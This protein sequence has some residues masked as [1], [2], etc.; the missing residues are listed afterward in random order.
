LDS[1]SRRAIDAALTAA[2]E[3]GT[4][5]VIAT[6]RT[7][8]VPAPITHE[9]RIEKGRTARS[10]PYRSAAPASTAGRAPAPAAAQRP[11]LVR[12]RRVDVYPDGDG[13]RA[14][15]NIDWEIRA[16]EHWAISGPNGAGKSTLAKLLF[17]RLR[18]AYGGS[19]ERF[20]VR[21]RASV[22]EIRRDVA[23]LSDDE[24]LRYDWSIPVDAVIASGFFDSVG[25]LQRPSAEQREQ[26]ARLCDE[27]E[28]AH[29][30][31]R[32][33]LELSFGER[34]MVLTAR[35]LVRVPR[36]LVLD[37][38]LSGFDA[39]ARALVLHRVEE[40]AAQGTSVVMIGHDE[41]DIPAWI[42]NRLRL[43]DGRI[44]AVERG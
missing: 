26:V 37:E 34:R 35:A 9:L 23:L 12:L 13:R 11:V 19:V 3:A 21:G 1:G 32:K 24:Q 2:A 42:V 8:E 27:F 10:G 28:I 14:L 30:A 17:G 31:Q 18:A 15:E 25:L 6:H 7:R 44:A 33:F 38:A 29:L 20:G 16:G 36:L 43:E 4:S 5:L 39:H 22:A 40:L 41:G